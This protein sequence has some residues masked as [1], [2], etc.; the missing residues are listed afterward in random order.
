[1]SSRTCPTQQSFTDPSVSVTYVENHLSS[2]TISVLF[3]DGCVHKLVADLYILITV[4]PLFP[5]LSPS[6]STVI[7]PKDH[8]FTNSLTFPVNCLLAVSITLAYMSPN[9]LCSYPPRF[10]LSSKQHTTV[11]TYASSL[12]INIVLTPT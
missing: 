11:A 8:Y 5:L 9:S 4:S 6:S 2:T 3:T 10:T 7:W 12:A 1:M